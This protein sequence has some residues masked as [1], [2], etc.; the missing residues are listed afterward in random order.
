MAVGSAVAAMTG[1]AVI[2][3][4]APRALA[5]LKNFAYLIM[6]TPPHYGTAMLSLC[7]LCIIAKKNRQKLLIFCLFKNLNCAFCAVLQAP[8]C[9]A[10]GA[11]GW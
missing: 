6:E 3:R 9:L 5:C 11:T 1:V 7:L 8:Y 2:T 10:S 4:A